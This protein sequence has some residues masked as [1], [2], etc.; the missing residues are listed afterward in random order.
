M[1]PSCPLVPR[2]LLLGNPERSAPQI[3]PD[4]R[5]I[6]FIAPRDGVL[7]IWIAPA[8][9]IALARPLTQDRGRG[10]RQHGWAPAGTHLWFLQDRAGDENFHLHAVA[11]DGGEPRD[12]TPYPTAQA[13]IVG[14]GR[15]RPREALVGINRR[16]RRWHDVYRIDLVDG[17]EALVH[18]NHGFMG[19]VADD[20]L[21]LRLATRATEDGGAAV[22]AF[23]ADGTTR[24]LFHVGGEDAIST[25]SVAMGP[26]SGRV[27]YLLDSRG[28]DTAAAV[29]LDLDTGTVA[30]IGAHAHAD[31]LDLAIDP[32]SRRVEAFRTDHLAPDWSI[33]DPAVAA[34]YERLRQLGPEDVQVVSRS[35]DNRRWIVQVSDERQPGQFHLYD[36]DGGSLHFLFSAR[37][38]LDGVVLAPT[39][40]V[41]IAARDGHALVSYLTVPPGADGDGGAPLPMVLLVH[42]GP[43]SRDASGYKP[44]H[45]I[46][47]NRGYAVLSVNFRGSTGFGKAFVNAGAHEWGRRMHD[48][49]LDAVDWAVAAG[50]ADRDRVAIMGGS[51]GGYAALVGVTFTP[52]VFACAVDIVGPSNL[53]TLLASFPPYWASVFE[54][55]ARHCGDPRN[56]AGRR[57]LRERSP[58]HRCHRIVRPLLIAQGANDPRVPRAESDQLVAEMRRNGKPVT[59]AV[60]PDEGHGLA[61]AENLMSFMAVVEA[62]LAAHLGGRC[63]PF[64][65][66]LGGSSLTV[67]AGADHVAGLMDALARSG[68]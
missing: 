39:R 35:A 4:G 43:W 24:D 8:D 42:G 22:V 14:F 21:R 27:A 40:T 37:P 34:D 41:A 36:R 5:S 11:A 6:S 10:I 30:T 63:E 26:A 45:Q 47:A 13:R 3:S 19:F 15:G 67:V 61:R 23:D 56:E 18:E 38:D 25:R 51:Y 52:D 65:A 9:D 59:Y 20:E 48:D 46:L 57:L 53:E 44:L 62:F 1:A 55:F 54:T 60:Y 32:V 7:N 16:D 49:L 50:I 17:T 68:A 29:A 31:V 2:R 66:D 33:V 12:L 58:M 64:G 28:R